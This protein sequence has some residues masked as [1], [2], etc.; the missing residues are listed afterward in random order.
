MI[1]SLDAAHL[2]NFVDDWLKN[3]NT[4]AVIHDCFGCLIK[5][6]NEL[7]TNLFKTYIDIYNKFDYIKKFDNHLKQKLEINGF[8]IFNEEGKD[9]FLIENEKI[10]LPELN[11]YNN[12][13]QEF[14]NSNFLFVTAFY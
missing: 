8:K 12:N 4:I 9:Y 10:F 3:H 7:K 5:D 1:H 2:Q 13:T 11:F 14:I 6:S